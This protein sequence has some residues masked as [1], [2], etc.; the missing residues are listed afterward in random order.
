MRPYLILVAIAVL[1]SSIQLTQQA[2][3]GA[4]SSAAQDPQAVVTT[5]FNHLKNGEL[6]AIQDMSSGK[7]KKHVRRLQRRGA[8]YSGFLRDYYKHMRLEYIEVNYLSNTQAEC[9]VHLYSGS[10]AGFF[11]L[12]LSRVNGV[13]RITDDTTK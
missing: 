12:L 4:E 2:G 8:A 10:E 13:W 1:L 11:S 6:G 7:L 3:F 5:Y 9:K